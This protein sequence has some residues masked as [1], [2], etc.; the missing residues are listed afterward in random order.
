[1]AKRKVGDK[2]KFTGFT[3][4]EL[5][6][7]HDALEEGE[8]YTIL[9]VDDDPEEGIS[10]VLAVG[11]GDDAVEVDVFDDEVGD[12]PT[13]KASAKKQTAA[14]KAPAK[15][16]PAKK[17][18]AAKTKAKA[19]A[20]PKAKA[21]PAKQESKGAREEEIDPE[22][23]GL[24]M[25]EESQEDPE[26]LEA[27]NSADNI[28]ELAQ[29]FAE[30]SANAEWKL[31]G[32]LYH[33]RVGK[34][35]AELEDGKYAGKGGFREFCAD[36]LNLDYRK[37][38][39]LCNIYATFSAV[40]YGASELQ[41][42]GWSKAALIQSSLNEDNA[43][44]LVESA[45]ESTVQ[46]LK[47]TLAATKASG[48]TKKVV[49]MTRFTFAMKEAAGKNAANILQMAEEIVGTK[50][51]G[52]LLAHI[53]QDW[54]NDN[55]DMTQLKKLGRS[56]AKPKAKAAAKAPAK[57]AAKKAAAKPKAKASAKA[58]APAK[59]KAAPKRRAANG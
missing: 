58:K 59:K 11:E 17:A 16:A 37:A 46:E 42:M 13:R 21:A 28:I 3:S 45:Q 32:I 25:L 55:L 51:Q 44:S 20:K 27:V 35:Y 36:I 7:N 24:I 4:E 6:D 53:L 33:V 48:S 41:S 47:E 10:Y 43:E 52:E 14:K 49:K 18:P 15:K 54:A 39:D 22:L 5:P 57:T 50:D 19:K 2:V 26:I 1:M 30:E 38:M 12:A 34:S 9:E 56:K 31:G 23:K 8:T 40:G 29:E